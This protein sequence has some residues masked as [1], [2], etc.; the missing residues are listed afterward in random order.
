MLNFCRQIISIPGAIL[1]PQDRA[2][3]KTAIKQWHKCFQ[4]DNTANINF[5]YRLW[6]LGWHLE[7]VAKWSLLVSSPELCLKGKE[8]KN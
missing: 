1:A 6:R 8:K 4:L 2:L 3:H 7:T 5:K